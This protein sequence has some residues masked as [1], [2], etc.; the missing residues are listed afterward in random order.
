MKSKDTTIC[1]TE[2]RDWGA[3]NRA[4]VDRG[5]ILFV[6]IEEGVVEKWRGTGRYTY[7]DDAIQFAMTVQQYFL[8]KDHTT[9]YFSFLEH[10]CYT[11]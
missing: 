11:L 2:K 8:L 9:E 1:T 4:L 5:K 10:F 6:Y 3:Y 7:S